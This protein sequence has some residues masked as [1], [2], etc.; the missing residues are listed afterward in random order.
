MNAFGHNNLNM[1]VIFRKIKLIFFVS[2]HKGMFEETGIISCKEYQSRGLINHAL[3]M[4]CSQW[5]QE[6]FT[7]R[8]KNGFS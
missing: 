5:H 2:M 1:C 8:K 6:L 7:Y 3:G 4:K